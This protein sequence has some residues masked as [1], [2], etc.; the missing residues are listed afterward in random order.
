MKN[1]N[2]KVVLRFLQESK[3]GERVLQGQELSL[4]T[5]KTDEIVGSIVKMVTDVREMVYN[6]QIKLSGFSFNR[7]FDLEISINGRDYASMGN[8]VANVFGS[9]Q[10]KSTRKTWIIGDDED[11]N[12]L[13]FAKF[14]ADVKYI[15]TK[16]MTTHGEIEV[17]SLEEAKGEAFSAKYLNA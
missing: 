14:C 5:Q 9:E 15:V 13:A 17:L 11:K 6:G 3:K 12:K 8:S 4:E 7:K 1:S 10:G 2:T 16:D